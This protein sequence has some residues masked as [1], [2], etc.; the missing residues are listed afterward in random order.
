[1]HV[2]EGW[3]CRQRFFFLFLCISFFVVM[4]LL[5]SC[6]ASVPFSVLLLPPSRSSLYLCPLSSVLA[7]S[8]S[9]SISISITISFSLSLSF[10][11]FIFPSLPSSPHTI[12]FPLPLQQIFHYHERTSST[13]KHKTRS[14][15]SR[16]IASQH[17]TPKLFRYCR[18]QS[19]PRSHSRHNVTGGDSLKRG[20]LKCRSGFPSMS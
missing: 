4:S 18:Q 6:Y 7:F 5:H 2:R 20:N 14:H 8:L 12:S 16:I 9:L 11:P 15:S 13:D 3:G 17:Q 1:M 19:L 10:P